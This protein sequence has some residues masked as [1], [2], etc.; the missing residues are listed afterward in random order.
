MKRFLLVIYLFST[1][2]LCLSLLSQSGKWEPVD[3]DKDLI[4]DF[5]ELAS[6]YD[7]KINECRPKRCKTNING[8]MEQEYFVI[9]LDQSGSM[10]ETLDSGRT[11]MEGAKDAIRSFVKTM[12]DHIKIGMFTYGQKECSPLDE[13][14]SP[15][16]RGGRKAITEALESIEPSGL[17]PIAGSLSAFRE[18]VKDK[19]G[20]FNVLLVTDGV[21]SCGGNPVEEAKNLVELNDI[22]LGISLSIA[23]I[24]LNPKETK[25][26]L[27][28]AQA[29]NGKY[30][31][32][33][34]EEEFK[35]LFHSPIEEIIANYKEMVCLQIEVDSILHCENQ[36][37][38]RIKLSMNTKASSVSN[39]MSDEEKKY[40]KE[41]L[42]K[43]EAKIKAKND[44]YSKLKRE[45]TNKLQKRINELTK[46]LTP[47]NAKKK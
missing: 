18:F 10:A 38:N 24:G 39:D 12:P 4:P 28:I 11:R 21:E 25:E 27:A 23:G 43:I 1:L 3:T 16:N 45:G 6:G 31:P 22:H 13:V 33:N 17:T 37:L 9:I 40:V 20:K 34:K 8:M 36:R 46:V 41:N 15:F 30:Y 7:P 19:K 26:L 44:S 47:S 2:I 5:I 14:H 29:S 42:P 32:V 35:K